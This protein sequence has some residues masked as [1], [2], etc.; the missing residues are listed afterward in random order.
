MVRGNCACVGKIT[1][2]EATWEE[3]IRIGHKFG[4]HINL[5]KCVLLIKNESRL[6]E[7]SATKLKDITMKSDCVNY[8]ESFIGSMEYMKIKCEE[9]IFMKCN[10]HLRLH[11]IKNHEAFVSYLLLVKALQHK[12]TYLKRT[13]ETHD[14][15]YE[16]LRELLFNR[17]LP[18]MMHYQVGSGHIEKIISIPRKHE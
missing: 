10:E 2:L 13:C 12:L 14:S 9:A 1:N 7:I 5:S 17:T 11:E 16:P 15:W 6:D 8:L 4:F 18:D 3:I